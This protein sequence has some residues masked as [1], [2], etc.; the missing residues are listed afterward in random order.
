MTSPAVQR[1]LVVKL[2]DFA[3]FVLAFGAFSA[4]RRH[5]AN[6]YITLLTTPAFADIARRSGWFDEVWEDGEPRWE[7]VDRVFKLIFRL[8]RAGLQRVY[9]L[10]SSQ[11][12][13]RYRVWMRELWGSAAEWSHRGAGLL[14]KLRGSDGAPPHYV[15]ELVAQLADVGI[16]ELPTPDLSWLAADFG[17]RYGLLDG[18]V[19]VAP[20]DVQEG[21]PA[22]WPTARFIELTRR[23]AIEGRR[24]VVV[25]SKSHA[26]ENQL[27]AAASPEAMDLTERTTLF[28]VAALA[29][30]ASVAVGN[31]SGIMHLISAVGCPSVVL[32]SPA[33]NP[34]RYGPRGRYV[35]VVREENLA[36]LEVTEVAAAMRLG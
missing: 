26:R 9:D 30:R 23:I 10:D 12:T 17:G 20:G 16:E 33:S 2:G 22:C 21:G 28:D 32:T 8:R 19:I 34:G 4:I 31:D 7:R 6:A 1:V 27:I 36:N 18:F 3:E 11:R 29:A 14:E 24:P 35:V 25:G 13:A 5:H 15:E